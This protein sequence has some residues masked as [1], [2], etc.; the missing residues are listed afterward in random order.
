MLWRI[1]VKGKEVKVVQIMPVD[2]LSMSVKIYGREEV[3]SSRNYNLHRCLL[4][5][6]AG[7]FVHHLQDLDFVTVANVLQQYSVFVPKFVVACQGQ[8]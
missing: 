2:N 1:L 5:L 8:Q 3:I 4:F 7:R 6:R